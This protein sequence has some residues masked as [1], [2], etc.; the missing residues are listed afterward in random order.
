MKIIKE[1]INRKSFE[2]ISN[3]ETFIYDD[4]EIFLK[5]PD[6][7]RAAD[8]E[9]FNVINLDKNEYDYFFQDTIVTPCTAELNIK[10]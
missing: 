10:L 7:F 2:E 5:I 6:I 3:F 8:R 9:R 1:G 4:D